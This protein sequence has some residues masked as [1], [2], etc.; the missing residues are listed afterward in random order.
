[1]KGFLFGKSFILVLAMLF[2]LSAF[3]EGDDDKASEGKSTESSATIDDIAFTGASDYNGHA[4]VDLGLSVKWA[5]MNIGANSPEDYGDYYAWGE[6]Y[7]KKTYAERTSVTSGFNMQN[8]SGDKRFDVAAASWG[9][10]WRMPTRTEM[11]ELVNRCEWTWTTQNE[12]KGYLVTGPNG[13]YIFLPAA[14]YCNEYYNRTS[15]GI[16]GEYWTSTPGAGHSG[17]SFSLEF[18]K[19]Q[20]GKDDSARSLG[21]SVRAV[22][23]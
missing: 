15:T 19:S 21:Y 9:G 18:K 4:A 14:G 1:M 11:L 2:T 16:V 10:S 6:T 7:T 12:V 22:S 17:R 20:R 23:Q 5:T 8:I 3:A 13:N